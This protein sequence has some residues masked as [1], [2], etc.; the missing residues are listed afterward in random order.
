MK[1]RHFTTQTTLIRRLALIALLV[2]SM[3]AGWPAPP[4]TAEGSLPRAGAGSPPTGLSDQAWDGILAQIQ[5]PSAPLMPHQVQ[6][7]T[8]GDGA[9]NH[10]MGFAAAIS[11]DIAVVGAWGDNTNHGAAYIFYH[12]KTT[13]NAWIQASKLSGGTAGDRFGYAVAV[14]GDTIV[15]GAPQRTVGANS[16]EGTAYVY[17]RNQ[18]GADVWGLVKT[19]TI[20]GGGAALDHFGYSVAISGD[21]VVVGAPDSH[22]VSADQGATYVFA[23]N[24]DGLNNWGQVRK[25]IGS[26]VENGQFGYAAAISRGTI[27]VGMPGDEINSHLNQGSAFIF[28]RNEGGIDA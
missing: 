1:L 6:K 17:A 8:A 7:L 3:V 23:R 9:A 19:L 4:A 24:H 2:A 20:E 25:L 28:A 5:P 12:N 21:T 15:V 14:D 16:E 11:G 18:G 27:V 10:Y 13:G 22:G 26:N